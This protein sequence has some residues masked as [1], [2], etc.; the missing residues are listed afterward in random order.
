[1]PDKPVLLVMDVQRGI[2]DRFADDDSYL[3]RLSGAIA[4]ARANAVPVVYVVVAF[5]AGSVPEV[6]AKGTCGFLVDTVDEAV[7]AVAR[8]DTLD[9]AQVRATFEERFSVERMARDY[10]AVYGALP[11]VDAK[12]LVGGNRSDG[13]K[14]E[15][16][17]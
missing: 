15:V 16:I 6:F 17:A 3:E 7:A 12:S 8:L 9:R 11:G 10:L 1:M 14:L 4:A 5:R 2:V 13:I